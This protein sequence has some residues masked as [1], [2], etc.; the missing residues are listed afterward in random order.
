MTLLHPVQRPPPAPCSA[1]TPAGCCC[2]RCDGGHLAA[3]ARRR[4]RLK[5]RWGSEPLQAEVTQLV[6][7]AALDLAADAG[8]RLGPASFRCLGRSVQ[9]MVIIVTAVAGRLLPWSDGLPQACGQASQGLLVPFKKPLHA[10][11]A[12]ELGS[13]VALC[14][15]RP[16]ACMCVCGCCCGAAGGDLLHAVARRRGV[17]ACGLQR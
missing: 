5:A 4:S 7:G 14:D 13:A 8:R 2:R 9:S 3:A 10:R 16:S 11:K 1:V 6:R 17:E 15:G 12:T